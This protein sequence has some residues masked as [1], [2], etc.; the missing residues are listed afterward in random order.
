MARRTR[1]STTELTGNNRVRLVRA[2]KEYFDT[3]L[4]VIQEAKVSLHVQVYIFDADETGTSIAEALMEAAR[5]GVAVYLIVDG[6]ASQ[7]LPNAFIEELKKAGVHFR[8]FEPLFKSKYFY[9]G[10]RLHH[11]LVVADTRYALVGGINISNRYNDM[12]D[13]PAWLDFALWVEGEI[14]MS[15]CVLCWKTWNGFPSYMGLTPCE[16]KP[17]SYDDIPVE[18][19]SQVR[20]RRNDWVRRKNQISRTYVQMLAEAKS[21]VIILCSYF[22]PGKRIHASLQRAVKRGVKVKVI[23]TAR[24]DVKLAKSAERWFYDWMLRNGIEIYEYQKN[25]LHGKIAASD[26]RWMTI[27]SY[28]V[29]LLS[30][31]A[32]IELNLDVFDADFAKLTRLELENIVARD[33]IRVTPEAFQRSKNMLIQFR[34]WSSYQLLKWVLFLFTFYYKKHN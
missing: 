34:R 8:Y 3:L 9:F 16:T 33:C 4:Q 2:G 7:S 28:N 24:S 17:I 11:K 22:L 19:R 6:Y 26:D 31:Y 14:A 25:I 12:P 13:Q 1:A 21:E 15:L 20:M 5:R 27:G 32:S 29:N 10:R 18:E 30:A 23:V